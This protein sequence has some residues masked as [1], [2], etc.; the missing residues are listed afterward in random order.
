MLKKVHAEIAAVAAACAFVGILTAPTLAQKPFNERVR[1]VYMLDK[2]NGQCDLC[3]E[4]RPKE[5]PNRKNLNAYGKA[6]AD[7]PMMKPL[8][9]K[10][11]EFK[12]TNA[13]LDIIQKVAVKI[14][15]L[16]SDGDGA[17]NKEELDLG[18][19]PG[20][21]KSV[22]DKL[23]LARYRKDNPPKAGAAPTATTK[24]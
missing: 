9:G 21:A 8:L 2:V 22:P 16:D 11:G 12:F 24:K 3:H 7:D 14:E 23:K 20:D 18:V 6:M 13:D 17:S 5:E 1:K 4:K 10:D 19:F 15:N